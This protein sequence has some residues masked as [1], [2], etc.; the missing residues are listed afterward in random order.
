[1]ATEELP[2]RK[3][4]VPS[5]GV[6]GFWGPELALQNDSVPSG[7]FAHLLS[8]PT[9]FVPWLEQAGSAPT[10]IKRVLALCLQPRH[11][12][13]MNQQRLIVGAAVEKMRRAG[14]AAAGTLAWVGSRLEA[15][16][17]TQQI[18]AWVREDTARRG[19]TPSQ[20]GYFGFPEAVCTS[21]NHVVCH[22]IPCATERLWDGDILNVDVTT[23]MDGFHGDTSATF[24][25]GTP[26]AEATHVVETGRRCR[27]AGVA[28][29]RPGE[30]LGDVGHAIQ[31]LARAEGC[32]V[33]T[34]WGG[35]GIGREM[36]LPPSVGHTGRRG[37]GLVLVPGTAFTIEPMIN[38]GSAAVRT[39]EDGWTVVTRDGR[40]GPVRAHA[41]GHAG[42]LRGAHAAAL[43]QP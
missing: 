4:L 8:K 17:V 35:H 38:L 34:E 25:I 9:L 42:R 6:T 13:G 10:Q 26:S 39:L 3:P 29:V 15:G 32:S 41:A 22:G 27:D 11:D 19:G 24:F 40:L 28:C 20:L 2:P 5:H 36:H 33:V 21:R 18:D 30:Q 7:S 23:S 16:L 43:T 12:S 37:T 1:V 31:T 14:A